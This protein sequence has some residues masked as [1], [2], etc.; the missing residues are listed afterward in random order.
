MSLIKTF[1]VNSPAFIIFPITVAIIAISFFCRQ[2]IVKPV[3]KQ[4]AR[5]DMDFTLTCSS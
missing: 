2:A 4:N 5:V 1:I 3:L